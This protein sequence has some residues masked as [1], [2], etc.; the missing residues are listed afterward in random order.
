[1][2]KPM[3]FMHAT[4]PIVIIDEPHNMESAQPKE[5][6]VSLYPL[7]TLRYSATHRD[8]Y[9]VLYRLAPG[10]AHDMGL[11][12]RIEGEGVLHDQEQAAFVQVD[13]IQATKTRITGKLTIDVQE[14]DGVKRKKVTVKK[15][16]EDLYDLSKGR[17]PYRGFIVDEINAGDQYITF[18]NG[19]RLSVGESIGTRKDDIMR[20]QIEE[21]VKEHLDKELQIYNKLPEGK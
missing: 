14:S 19:I 3:E 15:P 4:N 12:K 10:K 20:V 1:G 17:T 8:P 7:W 6:S 9:Y 5:A 11:V 2:R 13:S 18:T 16:G 21:T